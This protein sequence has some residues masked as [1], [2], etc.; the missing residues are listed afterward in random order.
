MS[1]ESSQPV[2]AP[3]VP[4]KLL[5]FWSSNPLMWFAQVDAQFCT[6]HITTKFD[7]VVAFLTHE[8]AQEIR[9]LILHPPEENLY[10]TLKSTV[11]ER[12][13]A[14]EQCWLQ[15]LFSAEDLGDRKLTQLL[16]CMQELLGEKAGTT[17][18]SF[19]RELFLQRLPANVRMVLA[20]S[21]ATDLEKLTQLP[22]KIV[23]VATPPVI[24]SVT[25]STEFEQLC[26]E[27]F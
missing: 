18:A 14:S 2:N 10:S 8:Y 20:L 19:L 7:Y 24:Q 27:F 1:L 5:P 6:W 22:D 4:V 13:A 25:P 9:D 15:Q 11:V 21:E 17:D 26:F 3:T 12:T 16:H 23:E